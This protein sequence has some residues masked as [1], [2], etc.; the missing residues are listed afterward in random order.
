MKNKNNILK[1]K[2]RNAK[3]QDRSFEMNNCFKFHNLLIDNKIIIRY[4]NH[5]R[6]SENIQKKKFLIIN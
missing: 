4:K 2:T 5:Q 6:K 1:S 3:K